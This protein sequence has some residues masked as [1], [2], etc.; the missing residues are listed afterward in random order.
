[1]MRIDPI[2]MRN[3]RNPHP[4][5]GVRAPTPRVSQQNSLVSH[6]TGV[7]SHQL[8]TAHG[9]QTRFSH[10]DDLDSH[11]TDTVLLRIEDVLMRKIRVQELL[12]GFSHHLG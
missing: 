3:S 7:D 2:L 9:P 10:H 8:A 1:M 11:H 4:L 6:H 5:T 12:T